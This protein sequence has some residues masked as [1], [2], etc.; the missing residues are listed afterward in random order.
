MS[1]QL[2][3][4][5]TEVE[6]DN[7]F[8]F[9]KIKQK[10]VFVD[11]R[12]NNEGKDYKLLYEKHLKGI[13]DIFDSSLIV[14]KSWFKTSGANNELINNTIQNLLEKMQSHPYN[15]I[16]KVLLNTIE[17]IKNN[18][19]LINAFDNVG[20]LL[21]ARHTLINNA[22]NEYMELIKDVVGE[23]NT[24]I[25]CCDY[26]THLVNDLILKEVSTIGSNLVENN[27]FNC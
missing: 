27:D 21:N 5:N 25:Y 12:N 8:Y 17:G 26:K 1:K 15:E 7:K 16:R 9:N 18:S 6:K 14:I 20:Y 3:I 4:T 24:G 23:D 22:T 11:S 19:E 2:H 13:S 10:E